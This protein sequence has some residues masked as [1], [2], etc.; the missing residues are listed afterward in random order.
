[1][2]FFFFLSYVFTL[3]INDSSE[4]FIFPKEDSSMH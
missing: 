1:M 2:L 4:Y 3:I